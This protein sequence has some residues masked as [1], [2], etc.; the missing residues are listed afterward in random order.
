[1]RL[2]GKPQ[3]NLST[4]DFFKDLLDNPTYLKIIDV[5]ELQ[6]GK[7]GKQDY[8]F[9]I[10]FELVENEL[11]FKKGDV[12]SVRYTLKDKYKEEFKI[13]PKTKVYPIINEAYKQL[14]EV[15]SNNNRSIVLNE[16]ELKTVLLD[17]EFIGIPMLEKNT[18]Y[19]P[20]YTI[21]VQ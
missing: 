21:K 2:E 11:N 12:V 20:Y 13:T 16:T 1:M 15:P 6:K 7:F 18:G 14:G 4:E 8:Y 10:S 19:K 5:S 3:P 9:Y 17:L